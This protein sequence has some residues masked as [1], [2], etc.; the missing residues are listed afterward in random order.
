MGLS[1]VV[2]HTL[3]VRVVTFLGI[4]KIW[5]NPKIPGILMFL[6]RAYYYSFWAAASAGR[7]RRVN[8]LQSGWQQRAK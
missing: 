2:G 8:L 1:D 3:R 6:R 4:L 7:E 5:L